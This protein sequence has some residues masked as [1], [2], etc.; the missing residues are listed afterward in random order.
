MIVAKEETRPERAAENFFR[1]GVLHWNGRLEERD[2]RNQ[3]K[4]DSDQQTNRHR[5]IDRIRGGRVAGSLRQ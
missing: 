5:S 1:F 2:I 4:C 3:Q